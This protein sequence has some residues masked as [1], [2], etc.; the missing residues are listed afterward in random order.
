[1]NGFALFFA[2]VLFAPTPI[3]SMDVPVYVATEMAPETLEQALNEADRIFEPGAVRFRWVVAPEEIGPTVPIVTVIVQSRPALPVVQGCSRNLHDHRLG[4]THLPSRRITL[5]TEQIARA[6]DGDWDRKEVLTVPE[7]MFARALGR[8]LAHELGH[9][10]LESSD[11]RRWG[12]MRSSL[13]RRSLVAKTARRVRLSRRDL[14]AIYSA[15]DQHR[16]GVAS[17]TP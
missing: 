10:F 11:H 2:S 4:H 1:M 17:T 13:S 6:I 15:V 5:W 8:V 9:L 3:V 12:L 14:L 16:S 7:K